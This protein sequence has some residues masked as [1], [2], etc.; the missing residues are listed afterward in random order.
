MGKNQLPTSKIAFLKVAIRVNIYCN[1]HQF[2]ADSYKTKFFK[3]FKKVTFLILIH[4]T[5]ISFIVRLI[6]QQNVRMS[7]L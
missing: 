6:A 1:Q 4:K 7:V 2:F 5:I 3:A